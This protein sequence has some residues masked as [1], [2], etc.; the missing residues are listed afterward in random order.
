[1]KALC[2]KR[3]SI[4]GSREIKHNVAK[5]TKIKHKLAKYSGQSH[6]STLSASEIDC[7]S[8]C[9]A[10]YSYTAFRAGNGC[11]I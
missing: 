2:F 8:S 11:F 6:R 5:H 10:N 1:L 3:A 7:V 9:S 4:D